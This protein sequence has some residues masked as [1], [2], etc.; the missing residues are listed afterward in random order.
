M[1]TAPGRNRPTDR[2]D[3]T[4]YTDPLCCWSWSFEK[5]WN[6]LTA[7]L[8]GEA[9]Y[10]Y[11]MGGLIPDWKNYR[12]ELHCVSRPVQMGPVWMHAAQVGGMPIR[13][14]IWATDPP[15]SSYPACMAVKCAA[16]QSDRAGEIF[17]RRARETVMTKGIN[18]ARKKELLEIAK[19]MAAED[20][21]LMDVAAFREAM[22]NGQGMEALRQDLKEVQLLRISRFPTLV[23]RHPAGPPAMITGFRKAETVLDIIHT[24]FAGV[25][26]T[27]GL[28]V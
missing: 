20:P 25:S 5:E 1:E 17:L 2:L 16:L 15:M 18:I 12:D 11:C 4:Y 14:S 6:R 7:S 10:R 8:A 13:H 3:V 26:K 28:S 19:G 24:A 27:Q 21:A 22:T 9:T 23:V